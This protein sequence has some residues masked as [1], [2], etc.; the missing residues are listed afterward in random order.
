MEFG[1]YYTLGEKTAEECILQLDNFLLMMAK[2]NSKT[3]MK[4]PT[5]LRHGCY[6][7]SRIFVGILPTSNRQARVI[8]QCIYFFKERELV[9]AVVF[10]FLQSGVKRIQGRYIKLHHIISPYYDVL[11]RILKK[12]LFGI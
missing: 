1:T 9:K 2:K 3:A 12:R 7:T 6:Y 8:F 5:T 11:L 10:F 4:A